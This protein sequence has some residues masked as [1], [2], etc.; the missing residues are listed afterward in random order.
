MNSEVILVLGG[1]R[2]GKSRHALALAAARPGPRAFVATAEPGDEEMRD[3]IARHRRERSA[4]WA[5]FEEPLAVPALV[6]RLVATHPVVLVDCLTLWVSN[7]LHAE[8]DGIERRAA[9]LV[10]ALGAAGGARVILVSNEVGMG[11]VP[12][13]QLARRFQDEAGRLHQVVAAAAGQVFLVTA[14][15]PLRVK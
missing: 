7:L 5:T 8:P 12:A 13:P 2:S 10:E 15:I 3:R 11:I 1:A 4:D 14:G 9:E 6:R